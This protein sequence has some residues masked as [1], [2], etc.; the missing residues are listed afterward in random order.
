VFFSA[1]VDVQFFDVL[2]YCGATHRT[3]LNWLTDLPLH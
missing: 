3:T 1:T 2:F